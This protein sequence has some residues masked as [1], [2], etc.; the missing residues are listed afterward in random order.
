MRHPDTGQAIAAGERRVYNRAKELFNDGYSLRSIW[1]IVTKEV[2]AARV[3]QE[4]MNEQQKQGKG[5]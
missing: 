4:A 1:H 3:F 2:I 5:E